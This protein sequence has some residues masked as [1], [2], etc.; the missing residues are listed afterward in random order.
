MLDEPKWY[1]LQAYAG[2]EQKVKLLIEKQLKSRKMEAL[3][4][5]IFIPSEEVTTKKKG[6]S[7]TSQV[8]YFPGYILIKMNL[9][10]DLWHVLCD[11][12]RV[13]GF[14]GGDQKNPLPVPEKELAGI[15]EQI[16]SGI[17][18]AEIDSTF[19]AGQSVIVIEGPFAEF[20][21]VIDTVDRDHNKL[22]VLVSIFGRAT[23][24]ELDFDK[25]R[26][27]T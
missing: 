3:V 10:D 2:F 18:Q 8:T 26:L 27:A 7:R 4:E 6:K 15:R 13:S 19:S 23:P 16:Q 14:I 12:P 1:I 9:T 17:K 21:G 22:I 24:L 25:V 5:E 20:N 11:I